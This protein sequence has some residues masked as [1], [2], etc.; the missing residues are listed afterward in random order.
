MIAFLEWIDR[1]PDFHA[2]LLLA[3]G[4]GILTLA[5]ILTRGRGRRWW[6]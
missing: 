4:A 2:V 1:A 6:R 3:A 5:E